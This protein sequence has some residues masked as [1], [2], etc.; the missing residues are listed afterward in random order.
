MSK[1]KFIE[2]IWRQY[3]NLAIPA[4][5]NL[6]QIKETRQ[7]FFAGAVAV[8]EGIMQASERGEKNPSADMQFMKNLDDELRDFGTQFDSKHMN[9]KKH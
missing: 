8:Y 2:Q 4:G 3:R 5:A 1:H 7:A 6:A 9:R